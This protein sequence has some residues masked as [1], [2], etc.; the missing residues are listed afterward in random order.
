MDAYRVLGL[1]HVVCKDAAAFDPA[2]LDRDGA[3]RAVKEWSAIVNAAQAACDMAA[4]RVAECGPAPG[5][6]SAAD[7]I[8]RA[9]GTS[10]AK[11][12]QRIRTGERLRTQQRTREAA[13]AGRLSGDESALITDA[14]AANP[15]AEDELVD[16]ARN[17]SNAELR[18]LC[19]RKKAAADPNPEATEK[20]IHARRSLRRWTDAEGAAH[21]HAT[22]T[23]RDMGRLDSA[24]SREVDKIFKQKRADGVREPYEA[25]A[26]DALINLSDEP[27]GDGEPKQPTIRHLGLLRLDWSALMRGFTVG[28]ETCEI[29]GLGPISVRTARDMLGE[30]ILK[31]VITKGVDVVNVVHLGRGPTIAQRM[32][33][34]WSQPRCTNEACGRMFHLEIDHRENWATVHE[35]VLGNLDHLCDHDHDLKTH[36][37]WSLVEGTG[38]RAFVPPGHPEHPQ[39][40]DNKNKPE[41]PP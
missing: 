4:A 1:R 3:V 31:L 34:L 28:E 9:T 5:S 16:T 29:A 13:T 14:A 40:T 2:L 20:R 8:A 22:G 35:T 15:D 33:L 17:R 32:A 19:A 37:G 11:A 26:F 36:H 27:S 23:K 12:Q 7:L 39:N 10:G 21:L 38:P 25:Y 30:S 41:R 6:R 18:E 24:I